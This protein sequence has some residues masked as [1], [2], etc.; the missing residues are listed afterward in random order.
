MWS[1]LYSFLVDING[2]L[3]RAHGKIDSSQLNKAN[4]LRAEGNGCLEV[5][6]G[7]LVVLEV[8][9]AHPLVMEHLLECQ[10]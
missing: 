9:T 8:D 10:K 2:I 3:H 5:F 7:F 4:S 1:S 6:N